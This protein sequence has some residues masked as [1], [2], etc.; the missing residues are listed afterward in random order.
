MMPDYGCFA[1]GWTSYGVVVPLIQH[2]FGIQPDAVHRTVVFD[3]QVPSGWE[4][5]SVTD[6]PVGTNVISFV[7]ARTSEGVEYRIEARDDGWTFV[8]KGK[9]EAGARYSINGRPASFPPG[10]I[11]VTGRSNR[12]LVVPHDRGPGR[13]RAD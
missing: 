4:D 6:L 13:N 12:V 8:L 10:G 7:R 5:M 11:R 2:V 3:P 1:I 9:A